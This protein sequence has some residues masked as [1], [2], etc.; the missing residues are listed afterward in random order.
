LGKSSDANT[1][2]DNAATCCVEG[3]LPDTAKQN[4]QTMMPTSLHN[5]EAK[6]EAVVT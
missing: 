3:N 2:T 6:P 5:T 4:K 1:T